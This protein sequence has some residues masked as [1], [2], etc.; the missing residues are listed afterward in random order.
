MLNLLDRLIRRHLLFLA[1]ASLLFGGFEFMLCALVATFNIPAI[2]TEVM[3]SLPPAAQAFISEQ[4]LAGMTTRGLLAFGW[5]HP[6][7][8]ALGAAVAIV[9]ASRAI[10]GEIESGAMELLL[11]QP[12]ARWEYVSAQIAFALLALAGL[13][14]TGIMG[15]LLGQNYFALGL[16]DWRP[17][18]QLALNFFLLQSAWYGLTLA[19]SVFGRESGPITGI[20]FFLALACYIVQVLGRIWP[21]LAGLMPYTLYNYYSPQ[22]I[23]VQN[24]FSKTSLAILASVFLTGIGFTLWRFQKRDIP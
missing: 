17:L 19:F 14:T 20:A 4:V 12:L 15:T 18:L 2:L 11:S 21:A 23:L 13:S 8:L 9:P 6:V 3:K 7:T 10:A 16:F 22:E 5:N 1:A 24:T